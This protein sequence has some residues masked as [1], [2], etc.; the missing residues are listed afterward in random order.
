MEKTYDL[1]LV[2]ASIG[3][4]VLTAF[5][6]IA[7]AS[8]IYWQKEKVNS[9]WHWV[10]ALNLGLGVWGM[11]FT[12]MLAL[13][14]NIP[15]A[16]DYLETLF[17]A[18]IAVVAAYYTFSVVIKMSFIYGAFKYLWGAVILGT[19]V[20]LMHYIG[21]DAMKMFP[22][23][24]Y[25]FY[26]VAL[27][28]VIA[29]GA[30]FA[31]L[32]IFEGSSQK[33][34]LDFI[35][36]R[37]LFFALMMGAAISGMHYSGMAAANFDLGSYCTTLETG[38]SAGWVSIW[39]VGVVAGILVMSFGLMLLEQK[40]MLL[41]AQ[42]ELYKSKLDR[43]M[44]DDVTQLVTDRTLE[45]QQ[46]RDLTNQVIQNLQ[47]VVMLL[48][49][50]G[51]I[52]LFN[53]H[54]QKLSGYLAKEVIGRPVW[55]VL[56]TDADR[57]M[58]KAFFEQ[59]DTHAFPLE[60]RHPWQIKN[61]EC[62]TLDWTVTVIKDA[63]QDIRYVLAMG[64][65]V[66]D[67]LQA[68]AQLNLAAVSF[69]SQ[70]ALVITDATG[71]ILR[72]NDAFTEITG[73]NNAEVLG[74]NMSILKSGRQDAAFYAQMWADLKVTGFWSGEIWNRK[75]SGE[76]F[77]EWLR[78]TQVKNEEGEVTH[79]V[80]NFSDISEKKRYESELQRI[81]FYD[82]VTGLPNRRLFEDRLHQAINHCPMAICQLALL[83][84]DLDDFK[85]INDTK[86]H[87]FGDALL[88]EF[89]KLLSEALPQKAEIGR[90][91]GDEFMVLL[92]ELSMNNVQAIAEI[93]QLAQ[94]LVHRLN[95]GCKVQGE[96]VAVSGSIGISM[97]DCQ[98]AD[99]DKLLKEA[100]TA[101]YLA[102]SSGKNTFQFFS[103]SLQ[104]SLNERIVI[105]NALKSS[106]QE[107]TDFFMVYQPQYNHDLKAI[108]AE[109][110]V[111]WQTE[112]LGMVSPAVFI[113]LVESMGL[114]DRLGELVLQMVIA[115]MQRYSNAELPEGFMHISI[116]LSIKQLHQKNLAQNIKQH[117]S[118]AGISPEMIRLEFTESALLE[119]NLDTEALL[120]EFSELGF[121]FALDDFGT[122]FSSMSYLK[123]LPISE[124]KID[125]MFVDG[126]PNEES[127]KIICEA[128]LFLTQKLQLESVAEGIETFDQL[129]WLKNNG[130]D[131]FQGF[132][133]SKPHR[134]AQMLKKIKEPIL[135]P[136]P[137][138]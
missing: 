45:L 77:P 6:S 126:L 49:K 33:R 34:Q 42:E 81:A 35:S 66:T 5:L 32:L 47:V 94:I 26:W 138:Q 110:L 9:L 79:Y 96:Q 71:R 73:F 132:Y 128:T 103:E 19:G 23:I 12:G 100:D 90:F 51:R 114:M 22:P 117:L 78:I 20:L 13:H 15:F 11:H 46:Q 101:M 4:S 107:G 127:D 16:F 28:V 109:A 3:I 38:L 124:L 82:G 18:V 72:V 113:P 112:S 60:M 86:G 53:D 44:M 7:F 135:L 75:K 8:L 137:L 92:P 68:Q 95:E 93:E 62:R 120:A 30:S 129:V 136:A 76:V 27:S 84:I 54:A 105:E 88:K 111:R 69:N 99:F 116:N 80:G 2:I 130:C 106:L 41:R 39:V 65:D 70:E 89:A 121:S 83:F 24:R 97:T 50:D 55:E 58:K 21:M 31:A 104:K 85:K 57:E 98:H 25:D 64:T 125:K 37:N 29:Y 56:L 133:L 1:W 131:Y 87:G 10:A 119:K 36:G 61:G 67:K 91:G 118:E 74:Q 17:S 52:Q 14:L 123:D 134:Y 102:K 40:K 122:G 108:G 43:K 115:D 63:Q 48:N 59:L